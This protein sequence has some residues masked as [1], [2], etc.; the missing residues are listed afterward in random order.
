LSTSTRTQLPV[1]YAGLGD[2][3]L[4]SSAAPIDFQAAAEG[5]VKAVVHIKTTTKA[6]TVVA[7]DPFMDDFFGL[8]GPR[9]YTLPPQMGSGS[10]V[11][12]SPDGFIVTNNHVV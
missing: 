4:I 1:N 2:K 11:V 8:F 5:S 10:G 9:Q 3:N 6:R 12:V 7:N